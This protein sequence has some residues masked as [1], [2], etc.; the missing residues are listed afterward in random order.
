MEYQKITK[1]K[2]K[3][4]D[5][6][7]ENLQKLVIFLVSILY[8]V[9]GIFEIQQRES[10]I[11][12]ILG[13]ISLSIIVGII[14]SSNLNSMGLKDGRNSEIFTL[15]V[16]T[17][18]LA[19]E[20]ATP[21]FDK[22]SAWCEYKNA[23]E[24]EAKRKEIIQ[25]AGLSWKGYKFKYYENN[26]EHLSDSQKEALKKAKNCKIDRI[27]SQELLSDLPK[28]KNVGHGRFGESEHDFK[29]RNFQLDLISRIFMGVI[30]G[31]YGLEPLV[32][33]ENLNEII[34]GVIWNTMQIILWLSLG[35]MKYANARSFIEDE[36]R[37]T[38]IIQKTELLN[39]FIVTMENNPDV[40]KEY[41]ED[42][43]IESYIEEFIREK[44][45]EKHVEERILE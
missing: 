26:F 43:I 35:L 41:D 16:K 1:S 40:I 13:N 4:V 44:R 27:S 38:H 25:G 15:S 28:M 22:L 29:V 2:K 42:E 20:K 36:Y 17:Y 33:G 32:T 8:M 11:L 24:L 3:L 18:G 19:K 9:Q 39:E 45:G 21:K 10:T 12:D 37:Q 31:L 23:W 7:R 14:I 34:S 30:L 5:V 6:F